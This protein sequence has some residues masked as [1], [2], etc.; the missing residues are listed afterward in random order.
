M[1]SKISKLI[2]KAA[3]LAP[4]GADTNVFGNAV[5]IGTVADLKLGRKQSEFY[6]Y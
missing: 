2:S 5:I 3:A 6:K 1:K 4:A